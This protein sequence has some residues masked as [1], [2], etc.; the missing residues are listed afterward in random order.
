[1][2]VFLPIHPDAHVEGCKRV[3]SGLCDAYHAC[4]CDL[5]QPPEHQHGKSPSQ[6]QDADHDDVAVFDRR[7]HFRYVDIISYGLIAQRLGVNDISRNMS[8]LIVDDKVSFAGS[9]IG[10]GG[11]S[12]SMAGVVLFLP[13]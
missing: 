5:E 12:T 13:L 11:G 7:L 9:G 4:R 1:M 6:E 2:F 3:E 10:E 8:L